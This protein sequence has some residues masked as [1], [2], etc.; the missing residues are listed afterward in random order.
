MPTGVHPV[1]AQPR[2]VQK[3]TQLVGQQALILSALQP[4]SV[5]PGSS[6]TATYEGVNIT[7]GANNV[8]ILEIVDGNG[9]VVSR[10]S[11]ASSG[12]QGSLSCQVPA[13]LPAGSYTVRLVS[14]D[15]PFQSSVEALTV[16]SKPVAAFTL[17]LLIRFWPSLRKTR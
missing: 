13:T 11:T 7:F 2:I 8:F 9:N 12:A 16:L 1:A 15:P 6:F 10:C 5:C 17:G 4:S 14:T 3:L